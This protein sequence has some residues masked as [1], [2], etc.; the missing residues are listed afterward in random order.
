[1]GKIIE[2]HELMNVRLASKGKA[3]AYGTGCYDIIHTGHAKF[4]NQC[5]FFGEIT[6]IG[7]GRDSVVKALKGDDRP[8]NGQNERMYVVSAF[9]DVD[10]VIL[11][12]ELDEEGLD[13]RGIIEKLRPEYFILSVMEKENIIAKT[14][15]ICN[16]M[17]TELVMVPHITEPNLFQTSTTKIITKV[18]E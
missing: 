4:F 14:L 8:I 11:N 12:E 15:R 17:G 13:Y 7:V 16:L 1:M 10:F 9:R 5:K 3:I 18:K 6:L 2:F